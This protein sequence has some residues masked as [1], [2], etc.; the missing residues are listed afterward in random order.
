MGTAQ[1]RKNAM[2]N[3]HDVIFCLLLAFFST[4][5]ECKDKDDGETDVKLA[6]LLPCCRLC[7]VSRPISLYSRMKSARLFKLTACGRLCSPQTIDSTKLLVFYSLADQSTPPTINT[8]RSP[9]STSVIIT[10]QDELT[11]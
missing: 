3:I 7:L 8:L 1:R 10:S 9:S 11:G 5:Y 2:R 6:L 4:E